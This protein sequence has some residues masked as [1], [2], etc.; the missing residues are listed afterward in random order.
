MDAQDSGESG[1]AD[2]DAAAAR[3]ATGGVLVTGATGLVGRRLLPL[4]AQ[5]NAF[6]RTVSR[7]GSSAMPGSEPL[8]WDGVDPGAEALAGVSD[9]V[10]L[11]GE[12]IFGGL[13]TQARLDRVRSSRIDS[14]RKIVDRMLERAPED[15]PSTFVCASAVGIYGDRGNEGLDESAAIGGS[16]LAEVCRDWEAEA[17]RAREGGVR[18]VSVRVGVVLSREGGAL[19]LMKIPFKL[20]IGG[21]LGSGDQYFPWIHLNDLVRVFVWALDAGFEG[22]VNAVAPESVT[23]REL[24]AAL[25]EV[26]HRP[27]VVPVPEF[28]VKLGLGE[29]S[30][31]LLGSRRVVPAKLVKHA[32]QFEEPSL[33]GALERELG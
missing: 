28:A 26:L 11:A 22:P 13:P 32:F 9:V 5:R 7:S 25:G 16:F 27:T 2:R 23:N 31:E 18:V 21:R 29:I 20:G 15:R 8:R 30:G 33:L 19:A 17:A 12:P 1:E 24:T 6:V 3:N 14:T 4:L 10:H